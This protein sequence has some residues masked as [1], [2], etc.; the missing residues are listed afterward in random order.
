MYDSSIIGRQW[1]SRIRQIDCEL[2]KT[3]PAYGLEIDALLEQRKR[4]QDALFYSGELPT[5]EAV[6]C[7][8]SLGA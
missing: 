1:A 3:D 8:G 7:D 4:L 2:R 6:T 5:V